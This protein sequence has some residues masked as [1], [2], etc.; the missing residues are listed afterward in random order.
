[1]SHSICKAWAFNTVANRLMQQ[2]SD[3]SSSSQQAAINKPT[4]GQAA[5]QP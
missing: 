3:G 4:P 2:G 5:Q 1:M